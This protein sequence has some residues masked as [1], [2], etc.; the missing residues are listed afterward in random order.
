[1]WL[2]TAVVF[3]STHVL[4]GNVALRILGPFAEKDAIKA[5]NEELGMNRPIV[6]Q[7]FDW[8]GKTLHGDL[9]R[10]TLYDEP[11]SKIL[12][13]AL[14]Y[15]AKLAL[16]AFMLCVPLS[17]L[18]GVVAALR[19]GKLADRIITIGSLSAAMIPEFVWGVILVLVFGVE[20]HWLPVSGLAD[21][22]A[23]PITQALHLVLPSLCLVLVL[24][25]YIARITRSG[26]VEA[27]D[28]DYTRTAILKG[29]SQRQVV[30]K[31]VLRNALLPTIAVVASQITYLIGGLVAI[32]LIFN[33]PGFGSL[34]L[35][36]VTYRDYPML[37]AA[38][39]VTGAIIVTA[40]LF[41]DILFSVLNPRIR[42]GISS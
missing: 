6:T 14:V 21:D 22:G 36:S 39:L 20:L 29:M 2:V 35:G 37:Q 28:S 12:S 32:E 19:R 38:V 1:L 18:G 16:M 11:V 15:S 5:L 41:A 13:P 33:Y 23:S 3:F 42:Q 10:S 9:G 25:G 24:F 27:L 34:L 17:I 8:I 7:Y 30:W 40:Q 4:P 31:H 26:V